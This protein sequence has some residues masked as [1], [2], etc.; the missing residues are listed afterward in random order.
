MPY[1]PFGVTLL[2]ILAIVVGV[3]GIIS[4]PPLLAAGTHG[5]G[6]GVIALVLG[7]LNIAFGVGALSLRPWAWALGIVL[8]IV[9]LITA[10]IGMIQNQSVWSEFI[11]LIVAVVILYYLMTPAVRAAFGQEAQRRPGTM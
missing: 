6:L 11:S 5:I 7:V 9:A 2:A 4:A 3:I 8:E 1:R 10:V